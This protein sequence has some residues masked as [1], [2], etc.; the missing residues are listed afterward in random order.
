MFLIFLVSVFILSCSQKQE[1]NEK[2]E[3]EIKGWNILTN[4]MPTALKTRVDITFGI[5]N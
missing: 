5:G 4:Q 3:I 1:P 2:K